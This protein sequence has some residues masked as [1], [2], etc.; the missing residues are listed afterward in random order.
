MPHDVVR[1][2]LRGR[3]DLR[4]VISDR[5]MTREEWIRE[6]ATVINGEATDVTPALSK[7]RTDTDHGGGEDGRELSRLG[8]EVRR[9]NPKRDQARRNTA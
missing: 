5:P 9:E 8:H 2:L 7:C 4:N 1:T 6:R 3:A